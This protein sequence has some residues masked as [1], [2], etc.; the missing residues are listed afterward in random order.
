MGGTNTGD[1][2]PFQQGVENSPIM[3]APPLRVCVASTN[4]VKVGA[5][6]QALAECF[7]DRAVEVE[8]CSVPSGVEDQPM[9]DEET[10]RGA[11]NRFPVC[12]ERALSTA[13]AVHL[14]SSH[15]LSVMWAQAHYPFFYLSPPSPVPLTGR[16]GQRRRAATL[17]C[18]LVSALAA[19]PATRLTCLATVDK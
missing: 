5:V 3:A 10:K 6:Q 9:S 8:G 4:P 7:P 16:A 14:P 19:L 2:V 1:R 11:M 12:G 13:R 15:P 17:T 18:L